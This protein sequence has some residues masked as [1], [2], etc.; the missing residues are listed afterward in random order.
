[1]LG[2]GRNHASA[3]L[4]FLAAMFLGAL[5]APAAA[6]GC[7]TEPGGLIGERWR[8]LDGADGPLGCPEG[9]EFRIEG[10]KDL[11]GETAGDAPALASHAGR[12]FIAWK[13]SGNDEINLMLSND[14]GASFV[15]KSVPGETTDRA[16]ALASDGTA[17]FLAWK[18]S[19]NDDINVA[20]VILFANTAGVMGIEGLTDKVTLPATA[21]DAP[22][23]AAHAGRVFLAW[24]GSNNERINLTVSLDGGRTFPVGVELDERSDA[25][26]RAPPLARHRAAPRSQG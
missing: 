22:A 16:P 23:L 7:A 19:D 5:P 4:A 3:T 11:P 12:L 9:S 1:M 17:L 13:G 15:A 6:Q 10:Q 25:P 8:A 24:P 18:G 26:R 14:G 20:R 21:N 2:I